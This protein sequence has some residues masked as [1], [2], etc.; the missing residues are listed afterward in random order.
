MMGLVDACERITLT[1][2]HQYLLARNLSA[3]ITITSPAFG[4]NRHYAWTFDRLL[5][6]WLM[7]DPSNSITLGWFPK[8]YNPEV[9]EH[10]PNLT[11]AARVFT[12]SP[13][14]T[15]SAATYLRLAKA[16]ITQI[17]RIRS[18]RH[19]LGKHFPALGPGPS[20][21]TS[22]PH[23][24]FI[25][26]ARNNP[27]LLARLTRALTAHM[28]VG[29]YYLHRPWHNWHI[30]CQCPG[31]YVQTIAHVL[32]DCTLYARHWE[33]WYLIPLEKEAP[34]KALVS[35]LILNPTS[36]TFVDAP[37]PKTDP[38]ELL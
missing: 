4:R 26:M 35:F 23:L 25:N 13:P 19:K 29:R 30:W 11:R 15:L 8:Q 28:P 38:L 1:R 21:K 31:E 34:L 33:G 27:R 16:G 37:K 18:A 9:L 3:L 32:D 14:D 17:I 7:E 22:K 2:E 20:A 24:R 10:L 36:F 6:G 12:D 5:K